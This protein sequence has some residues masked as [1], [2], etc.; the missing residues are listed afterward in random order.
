VDHA[1]EV[2]GGELLLADLRLHGDGHHLGL[3]GLQVESEIRFD[4]VAADFESRRVHGE[5]DPAHPPHAV[6]SQIRELDR[7]SLRARRIVVPARGPGETP[8]LEDV[9]EVRPERQLDVQPDRERVVVLHP[10]PLVHA[11]ADG[12]EAT[13]VEGLLR[14]DQLMIVVVQGR[15]GQVHERHVGALGRRG[16]E[17]RIPPRDP[18]AQVGKEP[19]VAVVHP[20]AESG[21][22][23]EVALG[24]GVDEGLP[25][26]HRQDLAG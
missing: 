3:V 9:V 7:S 8:N 22:V 11:A 17:D 18:Q 25:L 21:P 13:D 6:L 2:V 23:V 4:E 10:D 5:L 19:R 26:L 16:E 14:D 20:Q 24:I 12:P 1:V 15:I